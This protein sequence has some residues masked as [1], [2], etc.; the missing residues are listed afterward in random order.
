MQKNKVFMSVGFGKF[1]RTK[2]ETIAEAIIF[3]RANKL[4]NTRLKLTNVGS[5]E[6]WDNF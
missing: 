4:Q 5:V 6:T 1:V 3:V 2:F